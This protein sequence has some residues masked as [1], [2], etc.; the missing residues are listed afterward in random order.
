MS[1]LLQFSGLIC[2][3]ELIYASVTMCGQKQNVV[4]EEITIWKKG[5]KILQIYH[6]KISN[7]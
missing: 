6:V 7:I 1:R 3:R 4:R 5:M 2:L